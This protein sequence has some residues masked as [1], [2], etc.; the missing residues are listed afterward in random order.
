MDSPVSSNVLAID[1]HNKSGMAAGLAVLLLS[2]CA[3]YRPAV[4]Q[5]PRVEVVEIEAEP[6]LPSPELIQRLAATQLLITDYPVPGHRREAWRFRLRRAEA[7]A[8]QGLGD[9]AQVELRELQI[10]V[11]DA[12][13]D[14][15]FQQAQ[16]Y[17]GQLDQFALLRGAQRDRLRAVRFAAARQDWRTAYTLGRALYRELWSAQ[18]W[19]TVRAGDTL[20][21]I[22]ARPDV[23]DN[24]NLWPLLQQANKGLVR[25]PRRLKIG[26]RLR[27][28]VHPQLD[29]IFQAVKVATRQ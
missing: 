18:A 22:A 8:S 26:W 17:L 5:A 12:T 9:V 13:R 4:P 15:Y 27:Y 19:V 21:S 1:K 25:D 10:E 23:F 29:E 20:A 6:S 2:A 28:P 7:L 24:P 11:A 14:Y 16:R 3:A